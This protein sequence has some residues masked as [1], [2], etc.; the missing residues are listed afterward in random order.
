M[1]SKTFRLW[2]LPVLSWLLF[3]AI[4]TYAAPHS[5]VVYDNLPIFSDFDRDNRLDQV[6]LFSNGAQKSII[7]SLGKS[8]WK[9]LS[10]DSGVLDRG[11]LV[12][13]DIDKDGDADLIWI[14]QSSPKT[15]VTW[16]GDGQ[17]NFSIGSDQ[18]NYRLGVGL[19]SNEQKRLGEDTEDRPPACLLQITILDAV[20]PCA[21]FSHN[22]QS[23]RHTLRTP[24]RSVVAACSSVLLERGPPSPLS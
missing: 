7:V 22:T 18:D 3:L 24:T 14:S 2:F 20:E 17:G 5:S 23:E 16:L 21:Y 13:D 9:L 4:P 15:F 12:S 10:F 1:V 19:E 8:G 11:R 6:E